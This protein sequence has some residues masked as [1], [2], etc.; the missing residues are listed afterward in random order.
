MKRLLIVFLIFMFA[1]IAACG[2]QKTEDSSGIAENIHTEPV[3]DNAVD[4][5]GDGL[6][7]VDSLE[8]ELSNEELSDLDAGL[9]D[10]ENI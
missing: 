3:T 1:S 2:N 9:L 5:V 8:E 4:S 7:E 6:S 10:I